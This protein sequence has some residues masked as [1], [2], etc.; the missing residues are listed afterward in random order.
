MQYC[1]KI[2]KITD[3]G[4]KGSEGRKNINAI[5]RATVRRYLRTFVTIALTVCKFVIFSHLN[6]DGNLMV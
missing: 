2:D 6:V 4:S 3:E 5:I 1:N